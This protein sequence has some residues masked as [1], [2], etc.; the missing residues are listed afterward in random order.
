MR[1]VLIPIDGSECA[2]RGVALSISERACYL[3]PQEL[4]IH[5][6]NVQVP[7]PDDIGR[8]A[9]HDQI[10]AFHREEGEKLLKDARRLL[11]T[12]G[13]RY[14]EHY[15]VGKVAETIASLADSLQCDRIV[16][17]THGRGAMGAFLLGSIT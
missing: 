14:S 7:F 3:A 17:G 4:E 13:V 15:E 6:V 12:A 11:D 2:L 8:F 1:R 16:I 10:A 5:L 9:S